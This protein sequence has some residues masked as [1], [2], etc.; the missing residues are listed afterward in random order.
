[1]SAPFDLVESKCEVCKNVFYT[2]YI[3]QL[4]GSRIVEPNFCPFCGV[5][6]KT[7]NGEERNAS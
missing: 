4:A 3:E 1:M 2:E 5:E 7:K 6:F